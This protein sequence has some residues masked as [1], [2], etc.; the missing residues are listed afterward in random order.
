MSERAVLF[1][2][3]ACSGNPGPAGVGFVLKKGESN[4]EFSKYIGIATN[5]VAEY[6]SLTYGLQ[7]AI[8]SGIKEIEVKSDSQLLV[9]QINGLYKIRNENLRIFFDLNKHLISAFKSFK[10]EYVPREYNKEADK[11]ASGAVIN[12]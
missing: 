6:L 3:G 9:N 12:R 7:E 11:L 4:K 8:F 5:N 10:I 1:V 2:D